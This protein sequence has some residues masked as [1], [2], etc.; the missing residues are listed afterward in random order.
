MERKMQWRIIGTGEIGLRVAEIS[1][2]LHSWDPWDRWDRWDHDCQGQGLGVRIL[3]SWFW[4]HF[5]WS[6]YSDLTRP[7]PKWWFSK[8]NSLISGK[9]RLV[10]YYNLARFHLFRSCSEFD[11]FSM[12]EIG[13]CYILCVLVRVYSLIP[14][15]MVVKGYNLYSAL[16][17]FIHITIIHNHV[18]CINGWKFFRC[19]VSPLYI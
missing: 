5:I 6:N 12:L 17:N 15:I 14:I 13:A 3:F 1:K 7:H 16:Y 18:T 19:D 11:W 4:C 8:G 10:K 9:S 2:V